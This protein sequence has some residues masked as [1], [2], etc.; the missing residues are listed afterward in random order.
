MVITGTAQICFADTQYPKIASNLPRHLNIKCK[1][2]EAHQPWAGQQT[3]VLTIGKHG[4]RGARGLAASSKGLVVSAV[5]GMKDS[6][7]VCLLSESRAC[8]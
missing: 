2:F 3:I 1:F 4:R 6:S 7:Q 5:H 8:I